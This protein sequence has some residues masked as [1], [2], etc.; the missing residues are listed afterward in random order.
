MNSEY[1]EIVAEVSQKYGYEKEFSDVLK[2]VMGVMLDDKPE[3]EK[4]IFYRMLQHTPIV[5]LPHH[6]KLTE[7]ELMEMY[8]GNVNP[9]IEEKDVNLG[10][11][12]A[13]EPSGAFCT[14]AIL[15]ENLKLIGEKQFI[16]IRRQ[17]N[18][19]FQELFDTDINIP[20]LIHELGHAVNSEINEYSMEDNVLIQRAGTGKFKSQITKTSEGKYIKEE[21]G[22]TGL[23]IEE[24]LNTNEEQECVCKYLGITKDELSNL[25]KN[26]TISTSN[27][28][29]LMSEMTEHLLTKTSAEDI[30]KWRLTGDYRYIE[31]INE[32]LS[33]TAPYI[34][35]ADETKHIKNKRALFSNPLN[36]KMETFFK[37][38]YDDFFADRSNMTPM[39]LL[40]NCLLQ[41]LDLKTHRLAV[42]NSFSD[43]EMDRYQDITKSVLTEGYVLINQA[44]MELEKNKTSIRSL[45]KNALQEN[46][47]EEEMNNLKKDRLL[48]EEQNVV[49]ENKEQIEK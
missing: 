29:G 28:M 35:R 15:D 27:Y 23:M 22:R 41:C 31:S 40:D 49:K 44:A 33:H 37:D 14:E 6:S 12:G 38:Y 46:I 8:I 2:K 4:Q 18:N 11:Y 24:A 1:D 5:V 34:K 39:E 3:E 25:Y 42:F 36:P 47:T 32:A 10:S 26:G 20:H 17:N 48:I 9:H 21:I 43:V 7:D 19:K 45:T 16:Y 30:K 13:V